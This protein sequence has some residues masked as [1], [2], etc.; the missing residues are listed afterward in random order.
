MHKC[1]HKLH[2]LYSQYSLHNLHSWMHGGC[3]PFIRDEVC[4]TLSAGPGLVSLIS[5]SIASGA[6][7]C[8]EY[9]NQIEGIPQRCVIHLNKRD[10]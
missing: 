9:W 2:I 10:Y 7:G 1:Q 3:L 8:T 5:S 6:I 4:D